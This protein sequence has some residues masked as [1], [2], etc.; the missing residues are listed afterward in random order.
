MVSF[1]FARHASFDSVRHFI[2]NPG[3]LFINESLL[4][5]NYR[6][7]NLKIILH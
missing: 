4:P 3:R 1:F 5:N 7:N 6:R 2:D